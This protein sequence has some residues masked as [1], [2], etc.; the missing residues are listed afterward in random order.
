MLNCTAAQ[1]K[2]KIWIKAILKLHSMH[3]NVDLNLELCELTFDA[4][5]CCQMFKFIL[6]INRIINH[7]LTKHI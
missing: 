6:L 3:K 5:I 1:S 2:V 4:C 7:H